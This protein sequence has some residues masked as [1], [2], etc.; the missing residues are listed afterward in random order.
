MW[1]YLSRTRIEKPSM[2]GKSG[3]EE[4]VSYMSRVWD[5]LF[6]ANGHSFRVSS[7]SRSRKLWV[8]DPDIDVD[9]FKFEA[10]GVAKLQKFCILPAIFASD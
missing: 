2:D 7:I 3:V 5:N 10:A 6:V 8:Q 1:F 4:Q 9:Q